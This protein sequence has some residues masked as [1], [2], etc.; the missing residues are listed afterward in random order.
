MEDEGSVRYREGAAGAYHATIRRLVSRPAATRAHI[1]RHLE[2]TSFTDQATIWMKESIVFSNC[3]M[4]SSIACPEVVKARFDCL[5]LEVSLLYLLSSRMSCSA[6]ILSRG[7]HMHAPLTRTQANGD[8]KACRNVDVALQPGQ[9]FVTA[10]S[11]AVQLCSGSSASQGMSYFNPAV[12]AQT[13]S[14]VLPGRTPPNFEAVWQ[15]TWEQNVAISRLLKVSRPTR[16]A[17]SP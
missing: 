3:E 11:F 7:A 9:C 4:D 14:R 17:L 5:C 2:F 13:A 8:E 15:R 16:T 1:L 6:Q 10:P 12:V